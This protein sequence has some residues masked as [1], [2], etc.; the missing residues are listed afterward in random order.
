MDAVELSYPVDVDGV[1]TAVTLDSS[2][3]A[4]VTVKDSV[5]DSTNHII[6]P[7]IQRCTD[8]DTTRSANAS[9]HHAKNVNQLHYSRDTLQQQQQQQQ[10]QQRKAGKVSRNSNGS[11]KRQRI[12]QP[13]ENVSPTSENDDITNRPGSY[14]TKSNCPVS[15][16]TQPVKQRNGFSGK[17]GER[18]NSKVSS[19]SRLD[20]FSMKGGPSGFS[21][22]PG[23]SNFFG[24]HGLKSDSHDVTS[25]LEELSLNDLLDGTFVCPSLVN[26]KGYKVTKLNENTMNSIKKALSIL[27]VT[28]SFQSPDIVETDSSTFPPSSTS[29]VSSGVNGDIENPCTSGPPSLDKDSCSKPETPAN[30]LFQFP[31]YKPIDILQR[32]P[33]PPLKD[34]DSLLLVAEKSVPKN[35]SDNR[36]KKQ[37]SRGASLPAFPWSHL[38]NGHSKT[39]SDA[40]KLLA[41]R[42]TCNG[43]WVKIVSSSSSVLGTASGCYTNLELLTYDQS[44]IPS[45]GP[46]VNIFENKIGHSSCKQGS[47]SLAKD[48]EASHRPLGVG[49]ELRPQVNAVQC[50]KVFGAAQI[51]CNIKTD[52]RWHIQNG[53]MQK[54]AKTR[55]LKSVHKA[56]ET[57]PTTSVSGY[58]NPS[59]RPNH[60]TS[61]KKLK[62][63]PTED[64]KEKTKHTN[65]VKK[66]PPSFSAPRSS[67]PSPGKMVRASIT[68]S[69]HLTTLP[70]H[71]LPPRRLNNGHQKPR[72][73]LPFD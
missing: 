37:I 16:K 30:L 35:S 41:S 47:S 64:K 3:T 29:F 49:R 39:N 59:K 2:R 66:G 57:H 36:S 46:K 15:E 72:K 28:R 31:S 34:L 24:I 10:Q 23:G 21:A 11:D 5:V 6:K 12:S 8:K 73:V 70:S 65:S 7:S 56:E 54:L 52:H 25:V 27:P 14:P 61:F 33:L 4:R 63:L 17:R 55:K 53:G 67:R 19:K 43:K 40:A 48:S 18:R 58:D 22:A 51:L 69:R 44:L 62:L 71:M 42:S 20:S 60:T 68:E 45:G 32:L 50:P 38:S 9:G 26:D 1:V 13:E